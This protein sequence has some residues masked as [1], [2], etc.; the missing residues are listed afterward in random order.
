MSAIVLVPGAWMGGWC[1]RKLAPQ[2]R[3]A[4]LDVYTP[5][6]T[7]LGE[8]AHL[9]RPDIGL[10]THL[11]DVINV[12]EF[13]D[14]RDVVLL[15]HSYAGAVVT[16]VADRVPARLRQV[17][18]LDASVPD[19][20]ESMLDDPAFRE[21]V[22]EAARRGGDGW[23][24]PLPEFTDLDR[25]ASIAGI[26]ES[27]LQWFRRLAVPHPLKTMT[28]PIRLSGPARVAR[29]YIR[30]TKDPG[31][32]S[33]E[34]QKSA[35]AA[36][37]GDSPEPEWATALRNDPDWGYEELPTGHWPQF[38]MPEELATLLVRIAGA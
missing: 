21:Y 1:W 29:T 6:L 25:F 10:D 17:V 9:A 22:E 35:P 32:V 37:T 38:S 16:G 2:L 23:R 13:E 3:D 14:L 28:D 20:G 26:S 36:G 4:G 11:Q 8:R 31:P 18:Y 5:T 34:P 7:G 19:D 12:L 15:G 30:C 33:A 24:W 27:D